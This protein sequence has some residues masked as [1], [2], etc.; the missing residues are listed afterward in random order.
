MTPLDDTG[1]SHERAG[2]VLIGVHVHVHLHVSVCEYVVKTSY[3][4]N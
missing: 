3:H 2:T 1:A 4:K